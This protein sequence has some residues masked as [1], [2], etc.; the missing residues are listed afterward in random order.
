MATITEK[1]AMTCDLAAKPLKYPEDGQDPTSKR[2]ARAQK[3]ICA[4]PQKISTLPPQIVDKNVELMSMSV[5]PGI[6]YRDAAVMRAPD[7]FYAANMLPNFLK[8]EPEATTSAFY[9]GDASGET[10]MMR[11][12]QLAAFVPIEPCVSSSTSSSGFKSASQRKEG[13]SRSGRAIRGA[14]S[15]RKRSATISGPYSYE[16]IVKSESPLSSFF[17]YDDFDFDM[18]PNDDLDDDDL[19][20]KDMGGSL[21][22]IGATSSSNA[23]AGCSSGS[24][25]AQS[26][27]TPTQGLLRLDING[28]SLTGSRDNSDLHQ[29]FPA[30]CPDPSFSVLMARSKQR[31]RKGTYA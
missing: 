2:T 4:K 21:T 26:P 22:D 7:A 5:Y 9:R 14:A 12:A 6:Y 19:G 8:T 10:P 1:S 28:D 20:F 11:N 29:R 24:S 16:P 27:F 15:D 23:F 18:D 25:V 31:I 30:S 17:E 3:Q 13:S